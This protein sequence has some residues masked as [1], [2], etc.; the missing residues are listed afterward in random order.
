[1]AQLG[2]NQTRFDEVKQAFEAQTNQLAAFA[3]E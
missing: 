3:A 1:M 2:Q